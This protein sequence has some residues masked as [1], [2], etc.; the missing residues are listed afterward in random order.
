M[1]SLPSAGA[2]GHG[3]VPGQVTVEKEV[4]FARPWLPAS[5]E[6]DPCGTLT[7]PMIVVGTIVIPYLTLWDTHL[8]EIANT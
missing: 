7:T 8:V 5:W 6:L 1:A 2:E 4:V 3:I